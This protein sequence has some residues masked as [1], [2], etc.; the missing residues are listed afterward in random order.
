MLPDGS[1]IDVMLRLS[2][3]SETRLALARWNQWSELRTLR[4]PR[5]QLPNEVFFQTTHGIEMGY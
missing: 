2:Q 3:S 5:S 1:G 4:T